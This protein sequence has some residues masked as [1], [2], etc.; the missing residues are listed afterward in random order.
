MIIGWN[1]PN[2][3]KQ[4][5]L[6]HFAT[7]AC[8]LAI[9]PAYAAAILY[10]EAT[11]PHGREMSVTDGLGCPRHAAIEQQE[12]V[13]VNPLDFNALLIGRGW[14]S[15]VGN[16]E[17]GPGDGWGVPLWCKV[18]LRGTIAGLPLT[19]ELDNVRRLY[20]MLIISD[21][22]HSNNLRAYWIHKEGGGR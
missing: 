22:K 8:G 7:S 3:N 4:V 20:D 13:F 10:D 21:W 12:G 11:D 16:P 2:C 1:C 5:P 15:V 19:G 6:D 9:H 18:Q 17:I 14:D